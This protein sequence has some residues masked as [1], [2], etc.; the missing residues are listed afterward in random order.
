MTVSQQTSSPSNKTRTKRSRSLSPSLDIE[1]LQPKDI[2]PSLTHSET[3]GKRNQKEFN[4]FQK[5]RTSRSETYPN[6][7]NDNDNENKDKNEYLDRSSDDFESFSPSKKQKLISDSTLIL[8]PTLKNKLTRKRKPHIEATEIDTVTSEQ[9]ILQTVEKLKY[10]LQQSDRMQTESLSPSSSLSSPLFFNQKNTNQDKEKKTDDLKEE[11]SPSIESMTH[12]SDLQILNNSSKQRTQERISNQ[13]QQGTKEREMSY[14]VHSPPLSELDDQ[15]FTHT[16]QWNGESLPSLMS[17]L[18]SSPSTSPS[19][20]SP[21]T[22]IRW[23]PKRI[24][25]FRS[26]STLSNSSTSN[27]SYS[28]FSLNTTSAS[29]IPPLSPSSPSSFDTSIPI[30][31]RSSPIFDQPKKNIWLQVKL[32]GFIIFLLL[33]IGFFLLMRLAPSFFESEV[34]FCSNMSAHSTLFDS[35]SLFVFL[36]ITFI[37]VIE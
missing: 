33:G 37:I 17:S 4:Y 29:P 15:S 16:D 27:Q 5:R 23:R 18:S 24:Q 25:S 21:S 12:E 9:E 19:P 22:S 28:S 10:K 11:S 30:S 20:S 14:F 2:S 35:I 8:S 32:I 36:K 7:E 34:L 6:N 1:K 13:T 26:N 3:K 31:L